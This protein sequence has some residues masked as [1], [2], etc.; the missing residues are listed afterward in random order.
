MWASP[1]ETEVNLHQEKKIHFSNSPLEATLNVPLSIFYVNPGRFV[2][3]HG[4]EVVTLSTI[5]SAKGL[6]AR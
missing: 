2:H 4:H 1:K 6:V 5:H 3:Q